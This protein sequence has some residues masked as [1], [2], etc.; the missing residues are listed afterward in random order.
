M[1]LK[2][3]YR[4]QGLPHSADEQEDDTRKEVVNKLTHQFET[5][6]D[7]EALKTDLTQNQAYNPFSEKSKNLIHRIGNVEL[8]VMCEISSWCSVPSLFDILDDRYLV[9]HMRNLPISHRENAKKDP[10]SI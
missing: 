4:I 9:L 10:G 2:I 6:P 8:F 7:R 5:H 3:D 1:L